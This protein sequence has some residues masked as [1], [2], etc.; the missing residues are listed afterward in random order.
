MAVNTMALLLAACMLLASTNAKIVMIGDSFSDDGH[1]A[2]PV[3]MDAL[4]TAQ[5]AF[6]SDVTQ[7][8]QSICTRSRSCI[9]RL[10]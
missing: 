4:S 2:Q 9:A 7:D 5:V 10:G 1:G 6:C 8:L 3:V